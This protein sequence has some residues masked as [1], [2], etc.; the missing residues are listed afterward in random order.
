MESLA[1]H[2]SASVFS[3]EHASEVNAA[4]A[5]LILARLR[6]RVDRELTRG[7]RLRELL[8]PP[9]TAARRALRRPPTPCPPSRP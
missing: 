8:R 6:T 2:L 1:R 9:W 5:W 4:A 7:Q 3:A